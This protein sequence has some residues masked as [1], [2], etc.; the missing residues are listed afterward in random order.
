MLI[1]KIFWIFSTI[2]LFDSLCSIVSSFKHG[3]LSLSKSGKAR[4][5]C[6]SD[7]VFENQKTKRNFCLSKKRKVSEKLECATC[8]CGQEN[9]PDE[10]GGRDEVG[11]GVVGGE[12]VGKHQYPWYAGIFREKKYIGQITSKNIFSSK[13]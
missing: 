8:K 10:Q 4:P 9:R 2:G 1:F 12:E 3:Q 7:L 5:G 13:G 6:V 11:V